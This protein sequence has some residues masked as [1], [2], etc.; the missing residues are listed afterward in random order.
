MPTFITGEPK[1]PAE[2]RT[3]DDALAFG[4]QQ[5][6]AVWAGFAR[7]GS[8]PGLIKLAEATLGTKAIHSS[9][10]HGFTTGKLRDPSPKLMM[11]LGELNLAIAKA[12]GEAIASRYTCPGTLAK[13]RQHKTWLRDAEGAPL[14]PEGVFQ[15]ITGLIDL[16]VNLERQ[17]STQSESHVSQALG[18]T[19]RMELAK[20]GIDWLDEIMTLKDQAPCIEA[21]LMGK[22]VRGS[23][24]TEQLNALA[25]VA[26]MTPD[27]LWALAIAPHLG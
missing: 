15:A 22:E 19:L 23:E 12:N 3:V 9:Q 17:I 14:G 5:W 11:A 24:I 20:Q 25:S 4:K 2:D 1:G 6:A 8:Q 10:I 13:H 7:Q 21:L 16:K 18:K 27:Q 26:D